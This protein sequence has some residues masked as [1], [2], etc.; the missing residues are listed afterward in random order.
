MPP[1]KIPRA[2]AAALGGLAIAF[3]AAQQPA[4][5]QAP[6]HPSQPALELE[7]AVAALVRPEQAQARVR[8]LVALGPRM[9]GT[10]SGRRAAEWTERAFASAGLEVRVLED[11]PGWCHEE[12]SWS[13]RALR[14]GSEPRALG[15]AWPYGFSPTASGRATLG[16]EPAQDGALLAAR[17]PRSTGEGAAPAVVLV[18]GATTLDG[19]Y[20]VVG[21][22]HEGD[23]NPAPVFGLSRAEGQ[24]LR[25]W[26]A[27]GTAVEIEFALEA[28]IVRAPP[29]TV[30]ARIP[31][32]GANGEAQG[33]TAEHLLFC[34]HGDS[35]AGGPGA[36]DNASGIAV[37]AEIASAWSEAIR[38]GIL[39]P[40]RREVRFAVWGAEIR[41]SRAYLERAGSLGAP[42][43][44]IN[45]DQ[46]G[47][48]SGADQVNVEPDDLPAN[49]RLVRTIAAVL[50]EHAGEEG[51]P[52]RWATNKSLGGTDSY[53][54][55]GSQ[56][57]RERSR[58]AV[59]VFSSAWGRPD[60]HPRTPGMPGE[61]WSEREL[62]SVDYDLYY[63]SAGD[64]P[65]NTTD[66]E[67]WN[68]GW[69]ARAGLLGALRYLE[70][71]E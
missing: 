14:E 37:V 45:Y 47:F 66:R 60:E 42:L 33:W 36:D 64:I 54:F 4:E 52:A 63:H 26:L 2:G 18:D 11:P 32:R 43:A 53:V 9:G 7:D 15:S 70:L 25:G 69:C 68:M 50:A 21:H 38:R 40:P 57:F 71:V 1:A 61:S 41:S 65:E 56:L 59:T 55:S 67:P 51:F 20:P 39:P 23:S 17:A 24:L 10:E 19:S 31:A 5:P 16:L 28:R 22:L 35:D 12:R 58:P 30:V 49:E 29:R 27:E 3:A 46:A 34:A 48:G 13:V 8:E 6:R 62:V 44:V